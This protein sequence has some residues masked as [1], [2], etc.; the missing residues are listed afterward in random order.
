VR[1]ECNAERREWN[2]L[3]SL[4]R[5]LKHIEQDLNSTNPIDSGA[6]A[7][8]PPELSNSPGPVVVV[9]PYWDLSVLLARNPVIPTHSHK[10]LLDQNASPHAL[11]S[12]LIY[13]ASPQGKGITRPAQF[14]ASKLMGDAKAGAGNAYDRLAALPPKD[15]YELIE[16]ALSGFGPGKTVPREVFA[17]WQSV[18]ANASTERLLALTGQLFG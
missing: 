12:W 3:N 10:A 17:D 6:D 18:M 8:L 5:L 13:A 7:K 1:R 16:S 2:A 11:I 14:A 9:E 15:L 4:N